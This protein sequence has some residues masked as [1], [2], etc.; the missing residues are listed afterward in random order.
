MWIHRPR[1]SPVAEFVALE[2]PRESVA[3]VVRV[4]PMLSP[5]VGASEGSN[6]PKPV[7]RTLSEA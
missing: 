1:R 2:F 6:V 4:E 7:Q 3:S 5:K